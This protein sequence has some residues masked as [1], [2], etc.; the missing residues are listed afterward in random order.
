MF[1]HYHIYVPDLI[2]VI[3][4]QLSLNADLK[5]QIYTDNFLL[6]HL[7]LPY[8]S[9]PKWPIHV[10]STSFII[11]NKR[12]LSGWLTSACGCCAGLGFEFWPEEDT[13]IFAGPSKDSGSIHLI[14][15]IESQEQHNNTLYTLELDLVVPSHQLSLISSR[16]T[17]SAICCMSEKSFSWPPQWY[18]QNINHPVAHGS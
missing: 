17:Y 3:L 5:Q 2:H 9:P 18:D 14:H 11:S 7:P 16:I 4:Q 12:S 6:P 13:K 10:T 15:T 8:F 1:P